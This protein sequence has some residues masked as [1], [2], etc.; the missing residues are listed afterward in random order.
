MANDSDSSVL[1]LPVGPSAPRLGSHAVA[2]VRLERDGTPVVEVDGQ[3]VRAQATVEVRQHDV[4]RRAMVTFLDGDP[5]QPVITGLFV[6]PHAP[7]RRRHL[8]I[9]ADELDLQAAS[10]ITLECG[11]ASITLH[12]DGKVVVRGTHVLSRASGVNR[13]RGGSVELN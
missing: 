2:V 9:R 11:K 13:I 6:E 4:G 7:R 10:K 3:P 1:K 5:S 12:R 8:K